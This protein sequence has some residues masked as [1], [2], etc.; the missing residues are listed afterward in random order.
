M[1]KL[2]HFGARRFVARIEHMKEQLRAATSAAKQ[3]VDINRAI[4]ERFPKVSPEE[5]AARV[6][7]KIAKRGRSLKLVGG[8]DHA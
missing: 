3:V 8:T 1:S 5:F 6:N 2:V 7:A 4:R